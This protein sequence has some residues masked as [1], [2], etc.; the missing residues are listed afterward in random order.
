MHKT[1][2][3]HLLIYNVYAKV[4]HGHLV[5]S[6]NYWQCVNFLAQLHTLLLVH[7]GR[8]ALSLNVYPVRTNCD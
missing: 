6:E 4:D 3:L 8:G 7:T 1:A 5:M 2:K